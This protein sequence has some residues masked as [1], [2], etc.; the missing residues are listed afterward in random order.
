MSRTTFRLIA[1]LFAASCLSSASAQTYTVKNIVFKGDNEHSSVELAAAAQL[2]PGTQ[3][4][5]AEINEH[6]KLLLD[7]GIY[8]NVSFTFNGRDLVIQLIPVETLYQVRLENFPIAADADLAQKLRDRLP[9]YH[10]SVPTQ[11]SLLDAVIKTLEEELA[12]K[13]LK[14][15]VTATPYTD[16]ALA[17]VTAMSFA[18]TDPDVQVG[19]IQL[20]GVGDAEAPK[21]RQAVSKISGMG[22][23]TEGTASQLETALSNFYGAQGYL[24]AKVKA[25]PQP[26]VVEGS[27]IRVPVTITV[28]QGHQYKLAGVKLAPDLI[29]TQAAFD[30]LPALHYGETA[31]SARLHFV[32]ESIERQYHNKGYMK[33]RVQPTPAFDRANNNVTYSVAVDPGPVYTMGKLRILNAND[34]VRQTIVSLWK[35]PAGDPFNESE[36]RGLIVAPTRGSNPILER[37]VASVNLSYV[38]KVHD[39]SHTV[40]VDMTVER[41]HE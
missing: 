20:S 39:D 41:K 25:T 26:G 31:S 6:T 1:T 15:T 37:L 28:D 11:G 38:L 21:A 30:K 22:Y 33:A 32:W 4:T 29:V 23:S 14:A 5:T 10:G 35:I 36:L 34:E 12:A 2:K 17:K 19:A 3:M 8:Q 13:G 7:S 24:E 18:I 16:L 9:L 27:A 40:D